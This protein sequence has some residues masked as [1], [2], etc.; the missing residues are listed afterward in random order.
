MFTLKINTD[1]DAFA[2]YPS[3]ELAD[4]LRKVAVR[5]EEGAANGG[6]TSYS[7]TIRDGNGN[8]VGHFEYRND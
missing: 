7:G 4:L 6:T 3:I 2:D 8:N 5:L 1:N